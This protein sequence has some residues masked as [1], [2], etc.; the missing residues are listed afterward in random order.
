M[1]QTIINLRVVAIQWTDGNPRDG[2]ARSRRQIPIRVKGRVKN[3]PTTEEVCTIF[4]GP[5]EVGT[6]R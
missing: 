1:R 3:L 4:E 2:S 6:N 5:H